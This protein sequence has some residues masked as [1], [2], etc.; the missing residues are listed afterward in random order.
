MQELR[1]S[2][3]PAGTARV[4]IDSAPGGY[5]AQIDLDSAAGAGRRVLTDADCDVL[6]GATALVIAL[7]MSPP[8]DADEPAFRPYLAAG[9]GALLGALPRLGAGVGVSLGLQG[10]VEL[11]LHGNHFLPQTRALGDGVLSGRMWIWGAGVRVG[12]PI[13][14]E[15]FELV[16]RVGADAIRLT[17]RGKGGLVSRTDA[18][19]MWGPTFGLLLR[20][21]T[22]DHVA[23]SAAA[24]GVV[25]LRRAAVVFTDAGTLHRPSAV[26]MQLWLAIEVRL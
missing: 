4:R 11:E 17:A 18:T 25:L 8:E 21:R 23:L 3:A 26:A 1:G 14:V 19:L 6:A 20:F 24:D 16:P 2:D 22:N 10:P 13:P 12:L 9:G 15:A 5:R 7:G